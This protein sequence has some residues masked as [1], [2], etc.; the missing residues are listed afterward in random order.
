MKF[1]LFAVIIFAGCL[2]ACSSTG[3][4]RS[5]KTI[6]QGLDYSMYT[7]Y[8]QRYELPSGPLGAPSVL[9]ENFQE[10]MLGGYNDLPSA[11]E[12]FTAQMPSGAYGTYGDVVIPVAAKKFSLG[13]K[14]T[15]REMGLLQKALNRAYAL[16]LREYQAVGFT[17]SVSSVGAVN[18]LS[19][20][21]VSCMLGEEAANNVGQKTCDLFFREV[22]SHYS[23]L[24]EE[25]NQ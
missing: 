3:D 17:Y 20:I 1:R 2:G 19:D 18:P 6:R 16:A 7:D 13:A 4:F 11:D 10:D 15:S 22:S 9:D 14:A 23:Q 8:E 21:E 12:D 24:L 5:S 25:A